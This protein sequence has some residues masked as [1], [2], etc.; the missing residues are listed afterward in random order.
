MRFMLMRKADAQTERGI[1]PGPELL[2][3]MADYNEQ[4]IRAGVLV[5]CDGLS[6]SEE[7][8]RLEFHQGTA[9]VTRG[10]FPATEELLAGYTVIETDSL[11]QAIEWAKR[12]P[13]LDGNGNVVLDIRRYLTMEDFGG[14]LG[15][16][17]HIAQ[18]RLPRAVQ[19]HLNFPGTCREA[20]D[21]YADVTGGHLEAMLSFS[22]TPIDN[23][24]P[25]GWH[26]KIA[27]ASLNIRGH[28]LISVD[29]LSECYQRPQGARV[30]L[31][32]EQTEQAAAAFKRLAE[33]GQITMPF[34]STFWAKGFG[35]LT[36]RFGVNWMVA[37]PAD[38]CP[39]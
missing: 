4:L 39:R 25:P 38:H 7:G 23:E 21:F 34:A 17:K 3:A 15:L 28:R 10:P 19:L 8:C 11:E 32:Y 18:T 35:M 24:V 2:E 6:P 12:W 13:P 37:C 30:F 27:H 14:S 29:M 20:M 36:D 1:L 5:T 9:R 22:E 26:D 31:D 16:D 33:G